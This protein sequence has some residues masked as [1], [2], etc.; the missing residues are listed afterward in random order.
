MLGQVENDAEIQLELRRLVI[1]GER[2]KCFAAERE[3]L[4]HLPLQ[5]PAERD[6]V[7]AATRPGAYSGAIR[8]PIPEG[9]GH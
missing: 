3:G 5:E 6:R 4:R 9:P 2:R 1:E 8:A 7:V